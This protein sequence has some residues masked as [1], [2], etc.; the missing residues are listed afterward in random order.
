M[1]GSGATVGDGLLC[2]C[3]EAGILYEAKVFF[4]LT[5]DSSGDVFGVISF[6]TASLRPSPSKVLRVKTLGPLWIAWRWCFVDVSFFKAPFWIPSSLCSRGGC[7]VMAALRCCGCHVCCRWVS[8]EGVSLE[9]QL[10]ISVGSCL[11]TTL[12]L[13]VN[14]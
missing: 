11:P 6:L 14:G 9:C 1:C 4:G 7:A 5:K 13:I 8:I 12:F 2:K 10:K 3:M